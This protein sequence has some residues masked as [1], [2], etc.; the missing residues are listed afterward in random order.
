MKEAGKDVCISSGG[1]PNQIPKDPNLQSSFVGSCL[2]SSLGVSSLQSCS[3]GSNLWGS[4][5]G[6]LSPYDNVLARFYVCSL[7]NGPILPRF[8]HR[9]C[10]PSMFLH[11]RHQPLGLHESAG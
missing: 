1:S 4:C 10:Q 9:C 11:C 5:V 7:C 8:M 6:S 2:Q 3:M